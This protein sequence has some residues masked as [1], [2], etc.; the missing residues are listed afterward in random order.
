MGVNYI[1]L[2]SIIIDDDDDWWWSFQ[3]DAKRRPVIFFLNSYEL[4]EFVGTYCIRHKT[5]QVSLNPSGCFCLMDDGRH[6][7]IRFYSASTEQNRVPLHTALNTRIQESWWHYVW[8]DGWISWI[9]M[10]FMLNMN[11]LICYRNQSSE[12]DSIAN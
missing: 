6:S 1:I 9:I 4:F 11:W 8:C 7:F 3:F 12:S 10:L 5:F 2:N